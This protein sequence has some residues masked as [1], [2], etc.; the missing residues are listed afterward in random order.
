MKLQIVKLHA[1]AF[2]FTKNPTIPV[3]ELAAEI[4]VSEGAIYRWA[5]LPEWDNALNELGFT[6][7]RKFHR[8]PRRSLQ[9]ESGSIVEQAEILIDQLTADG[10]TEKQAVTRTAEMLNLP[11]RRVYEWNKKRKDRID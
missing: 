9:R 5:R 1:A 4:E 8:E 10:L 2:I 6:G 7:E 11:R 3:S